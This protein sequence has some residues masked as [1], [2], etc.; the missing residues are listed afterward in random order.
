MNQS[1]KVTY[2]IQKEK[3]ISLKATIW[4]DSTQ[5]FLSLVTPLVLHKRDNKYLAIFVYQNGKPKQIVSLQIA[6]KTVD[7]MILYRL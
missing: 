7:N 4:E 3:F 2:I 6:Y 5:Q 1:L